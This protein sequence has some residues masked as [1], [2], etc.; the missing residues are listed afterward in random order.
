V[1]QFFDPE[2][3]FQFEECKNSDFYDWLNS[4]NA[5][6]KQFIKPCNEHPNL[7]GRR[8]IA[9]I[10]SNKLFSTGIDRF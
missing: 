1:L 4:G 9:E 6:V 2:Y 7:S 8:K 3:F 10:V 5:Q